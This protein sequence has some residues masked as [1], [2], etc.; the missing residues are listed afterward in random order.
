MKHLTIAPVL[1]LSILFHWGSAWAQTFPPEPGRGQTILSPSYDG[2]GAEMLTLADGLRQVMNN[3][4]QVQITRLEENMAAADTGTARAGLLPSANTSLSHTSLAYQP[5]AI[6]TS[7]GVSI[8]ILPGILIGAGTQHIPQYQRNFWSYSISVQQTLFDFWSSLSRYRASQE[9]L[10]NKKLDTARVQNVIALDF[11]VAFFDFLEAEKMVEL[12]RK[13]VERLEAHLRDARNLYASGAI[14]R[15]DLLQAE[16][17]LSDGQQKLLNASNGRD[18]QASKVNYLLLRPLNATLRVLDPEFQVR[19]GP[20]TVEEAWNLALQQRP[21]IQIVDGSLKALKLEETARKADYYPRLF[22]KG[23]YDYTEN[24]YMVHEDNWSLIFG[25]TLNLFA[26]GSTQAQVAKNHYQQAQ[27]LQQRDK[28]LDD[29]RLEVKR[30][31]LDLQNARERIRVN[32]GAA[33]QAQE[34]LRINNVRYAEGVGTA[35]EVLDAVTLLTTS[36]TNYVR[37]IYDFRRAEA[38]A[39]YA[40]GKDLREVYR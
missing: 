15:N 17:R 38:A 39:Y 23:G 8:P 30:Y 27:T 29:I 24:R 5:Q 10:V 37:S 35:T 20:F 4:R 19:E 11:A 21:E 3:S 14:T 9:I 33:D 32:Q 28:L 16:V 36:E 7:P 1:I 25:F 40:V 31:L 13:E 34:N 26:G 18:L 12:A 22:A 6:F 2:S